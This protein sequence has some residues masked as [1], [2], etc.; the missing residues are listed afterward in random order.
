MGDRRGLRAE[1][2][3]LSGARGHGSRVM[4]RGRREDWGLLGDAWWPHGAGGRHLRAAGQE[5][6]GRVALLMGHLVQPG[7]C[8]RQ[9]V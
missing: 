2:W 9:G 4:G 8:E 5:G 6:K 1:D 7:Q 3:G